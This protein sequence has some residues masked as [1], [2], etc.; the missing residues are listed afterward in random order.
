LDA[1]SRYKKELSTTTTSIDRPA[2]VQ[3]A[4]EFLVYLI[5]FSIPFSIRINAYATIA[6]VI[7]YIVYAIAT[8]DAGKG[9]FKTPLFAMVILQLVIMLLGL[10]H[11]ADVSQGYME[12]ERFLYAVV[13]TIVVFKARDTRVTIT[14]VVMSFAAGCLLLSLYGLTWSLV[15]VNDLPWHDR[16]SEII[17]V[18]PTYFT[19]YLVFIFFFFAELLRFGFK[20]YSTGQ[21]AVV[22]ALLIYVVALILFVRS[23]LGLLI[24]AVVAVM[25]PVIVYKKRAALLT[26]I[27]FTVAL[28]VY[29]LDSARAS[30][31]F[32]SYGT[33]VSG[34][35]G[36][37]FKLWGGAMEAISLK[38]VFGA[39]T[40]GEQLLLN[41]GYKRT[42]Y[43]AGIANSY[44]AHNQYLEY[45]VRNG[46][47]ALLSFIALLIYSF[48]VSL[49]RS[50]YLFL[51][52][53]MMFVLGMIAESS[54]NVHKGIV[55][56]YFLLATCV[57]LPFSRSSQAFDGQ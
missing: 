33:N 16:F 32:D 20:S 39:G 35:L 26:F 6:C 27:L 15:E 23:Q 54:L 57:F 14:K 50:N 3:R 34:A 51:I 19:L 28:I 7:C 56:F 1:T 37:R 42:G 44:N 46:I 38:P 22:V 45:L 18:H 53:N 41:E 10:T 11:S 36:D 40:G 30:T 9:L 47:L 49:R 5:A 13:T 4:F 52:F 31:F 48:R 55:F 24:F 25:Y 43:E 17:H 29:F 2:G 12:I 21:R 8:K